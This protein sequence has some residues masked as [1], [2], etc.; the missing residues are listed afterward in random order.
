MG[1][2]IPIISPGLSASSDEQEANRGL[3]GDGENR[4]AVL[5]SNKRS[6]ARSGIVV[7]RSTISPGSKCDGGLKIKRA[8]GVTRHVAG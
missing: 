6:K 3:R 7:V 1:M 8:N 2:T 4:E 5:L